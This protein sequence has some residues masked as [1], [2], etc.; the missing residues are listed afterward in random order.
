MTIQEHVAIGTKT[1]MKIGGTARYY[2]ELLTKEDVEEAV[3]FASENHLPLIP[4]GGGSNTVFAD[5]EIN[6]LVVRMKADHVEINGPSTELGMRLVTV[7]A[8]K[9]MG[10]FLNELAEKNLDLS[11]LTGIPGTVGGAIFGNAGQG[12]G[13]I[14]IDQF[15]QTVTAYVDGKWTSFNREE[16]KFRY[17]ESVFKDLSSTP[18]P[19][20]TGGGVDSEGGRGGGSPVIIWEVVLQIPS[21]PASEVKAEIER[22]LRKR[23]E[24]QPHVKTA[25]SCFK[26]LPDGT[27]AWKL[28]D[29]AGLRGTTI[30]GVQI[31]EKHANF[32]LNTGGGT[33]ED[34][35]KITA[36][37]KE[38]VPTIASIEMRLFKQDGSLF[39]P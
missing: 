37:V 25:G 19:S 1:T 32:L 11:A 17:R 30:G 16:C 15:V 2:A 4:F 23:I 5:G 33:F 10:S 3:K 26:S 6:A 27:P 35:A 29:A 14:W 21:R 18:N 36:L 31:A 13:G 12:A 28:I 9:I 38:K 20:S 24:T 39:Q 34:V 7:Q 8:G 22:H